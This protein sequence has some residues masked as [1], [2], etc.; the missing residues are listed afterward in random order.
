M[1]TPVSNTDPDADLAVVLGPG[2]MAYYTQVENYPV[3]ADRKAW[4][5]LTA[6]G[7][8]LTVLTFFGPSLSKL[9]HHPKWWVAALVLSLLVALAILLLL[10]AGT[11]FY[12]FTILPRVPAECLCFYRH[13]AARPREQY[14]RDVRALSHAEAMRE[15][16]NYN[17]SIAC[18]GAAKFRAVGWSMHWMR[19][20]I[21][22]W[23]LLLLIIAVMG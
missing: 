19:L 13:I 8:I 9:L 10:V 4:F 2:R 7:L 6:S 14:E 3:L 23:M 12:G 22:L 21:L 1:P 11:A 15:V 18:Q 16:L 17:Y 5:L 20:A